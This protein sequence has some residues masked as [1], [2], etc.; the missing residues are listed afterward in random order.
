M[1]KK[2]LGIIAIFLI[3]VALIFILTQRQRPFFQADVS[4]IEIEPIR[5]GRYEELL[6]NVNPF[7]LY[8]EI[9]PYIDQ[10]YVFLGDAIHTES[11]QQKL[12]DYV[13]DPVIREIYLDTRKVWPDVDDLENEL[14]EAF[15]FYRYHF[16]EELIPQI[17]TYISGIDYNYPVKYYD[18]VMVIGLDLYLGSDH[19]LYSKAGVAEFK[20]LDMHPRAVVV[21]IF[22]MLAEKHLQNTGF[23]P[24]QFL[25]FMIYEGKVLYF[26]DSMLPKHPD[27][28]KI[29]YTSTQY[30][31]MQANIERVW[32]YFLENELLYSGD[33]PTISQFIGEA[34]FTSPF[35]QDSP[36]RTAA[37]IGWQIVRDYM[38]NHPE[39]TLSGLV[40]E[41]DS[42]KILRMSRFRP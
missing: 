10:F 34:P 16:S 37:Y 40:N 24:E 31:W 14:T 4:G 27:S 1:N 17:F 21:D 32:T 9:T 19:P 25:D 33:R 15:R 38:R 6:F 26:L 42:R 12:F 23:V 39:V 22:R 41:K 13:T 7:N 8:Q 29:A 11:G 20:R 18:N 35:S 2:I 5:I 28:L 36:P 3:A 30:E